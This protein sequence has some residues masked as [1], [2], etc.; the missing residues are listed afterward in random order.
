MFVEHG[1]DL[2]AVDDEIRATPLGW[3][4]RRGQA[5]AVQYLLDH[6]ADPNGGGASWSRPLAW[7]ADRPDDEIGVMLRGA[8][9]NLP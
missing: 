9:A 8:G 7:V 5:E 4:A 3:A 2:E 6:G 1:A